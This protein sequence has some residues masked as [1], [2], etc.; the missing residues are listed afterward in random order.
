MHEAGAAFH[1]APRSLAK[2]GA[3]LTKLG[4][5]LTK[6]RAASR[7]SGQAS[8]SSR[9]PSRSSECGSRSVFRAVPRSCAFPRI[10]V[11]RSRTE[12][13]LQQLA[14]AA[15]RRELGGR[16]CPQPSVLAGLPLRA[17]RSPPR[18]MVARCECLAA[19]VL[20]RAPF[21]PPV[22][23]GSKPLD[24][25]GMTVYDILEYL[26][27]SSLARGTRARGVPRTATLAAL[28]GPA[29]CSQ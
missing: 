7:S 16:S 29:F 27:Y 4:A 21:A 24:R 25:P 26:G 11:D 1:R 12:V 19:G 9:Q 6:L 18:A 28:R 20:M 2:L 3:G 13:H 8:R 14:Y 22:L 17:G 15:V 10:S 5:G 23:R